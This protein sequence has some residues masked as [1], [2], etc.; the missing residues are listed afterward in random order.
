[1]R[2]KKFTGLCEHLLDTC[3]HKYENQALVFMFLIE[4][5]RKQTKN[6]NINHKINK[7]CLQFAVKFKI[8]I[9][10]QILLC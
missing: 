8:K 10:H 7:E 5:E 1:M 2:L 3:T 6:I 9:F 4:V